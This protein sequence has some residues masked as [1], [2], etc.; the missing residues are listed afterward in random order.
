VFLGIGRLIVAP[1]EMFI[2]NNVSGMLLPAAET[3]LLKSGHSF[4]RPCN[5]HDKIPVLPAPAICL[6]SRKRVRIEIHPHHVPIMARAT[7]TITVRKP[8]RHCA[9]PTP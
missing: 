2:S 3:S 8:N 1:D 5:V 4:C 7:M 6:Q 9:C